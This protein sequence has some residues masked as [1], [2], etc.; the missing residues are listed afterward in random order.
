M[1]NLLFHKQALL[2][3][4]ISLARYDI[5]LTPYDILAFSKH[6]II[7]VPSYAERISPA[8]QISYHPVYHPFPKGTD[9]TV[10]S[11][12]CQKTNQAFYMLKSS[13]TVRMRGKEK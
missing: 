5:R 13:I 11:L 10:K 3:H 8:K 7:S 2:Y 1:S 6:D 9:I 4:D 12:I